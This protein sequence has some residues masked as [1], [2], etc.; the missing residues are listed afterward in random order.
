MCKKI[1]NKI[2]HYFP[3]KK[4]TERIVPYLTLGVTLSAIIIGGLWALIDYYLDSEAKRE[5]SVMKL[6]E[7][8]IGSDTTV[9]SLKDLQESF[10]ED[11]LHIVKSATC[12]VEQTNEDNTIGQMM[13]RSDNHN[14]SFTVATETC[15]RSSEEIR[16]TITKIKREK[17]Y[18]SDNITKIKK[19]LDHYKS[20]VLCADFKKCDKP[21]VIKYYSDE[22]LT[23]INAFCDYF[24]QDREN[25]KKNAPE[26]LVI[27]TFLVN[28]WHHRENSANRIDQS[29][30]LRFFCV[31]HNSLLK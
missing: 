7:Q 1:F 29:K 28:N 2:V 14:S 11:L 4:I 26:D 5:Q 18:T 22:M 21:T 12:T 20:V 10:D 27:S 15:Q 17:L 31:S 16:I 6:Y 3:T 23:Y 25:W 19:L 13:A 9:D 30:E 8:F 24:E